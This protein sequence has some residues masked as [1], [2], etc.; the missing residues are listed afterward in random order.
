ML[1][2]YARVSDKT[3]KID[4]QL[5]EL[6]NAGVEKI[7]HETYTGTNFEKRTEYNK[8]I[9]FAREGDF[10]VVD[11]LERLGRSYNELIKIVS[12]LDNN[13]IGLM[14]LNLPIL[15]ECGR[16]EL[17]NKLIR[18]LIIQ[19]YSYMAEQDLVEMKRKQAQGI[20]VAKEKGIYKGKPREYS[21]KAKNPQKRLIYNSIVL[22]LYDNVSVSQISKETGVTRPTIYKIKKEVQTLF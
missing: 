2:G 12:H 20:A 22:M 5:L 19:L 3:Q 6:K 21:A 11:S 7:F 10:I 14:V 1:I 13:N 18:N 8:M 4:R 9:Q 17:L 15:Q 16:D